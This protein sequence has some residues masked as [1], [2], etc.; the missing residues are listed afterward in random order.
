LFLNNKS[1]GKRTIDKNT[2]LGT[3]PINFKSGT[4]KAIG[5]NVNKKV[6]ENILKTAGEP[7]RMIAKPTKSVLVADGK[8]MSLIEISFVDKNKNPVYDANN[9]I[10]VNVTGN[11]SLA[12]LDTGDMFYTGIFKNNVRKVHHGKLLLTVK[13]AE[14][15]GEI[16]V[17]LKSEKLETLKFELIT[18]K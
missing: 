12:G 9:E 13:S 4:L 8:D 14:T 16:H 3:W 7:V 10:E 15:A 5:Y 11:G 18:K 6:T 17:E 2:Y 1:L